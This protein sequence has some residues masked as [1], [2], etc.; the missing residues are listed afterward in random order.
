MCEQTVVIIVNRGRVPMRDAVEQRLLCL[1]TLN[2]RNANRQLVDATLLPLNS[3]IERHL[4]HLLR[5]TLDELSRLRMNTNGEG[6]DVASQFLCGG[7]HERETAAVA[8]GEATPHNSRIKQRKEAAV[9]G[10]HLHVGS[11][12]R[13]L[14][15]QW[16]GE[17]TVRTSLFIGSR[18]C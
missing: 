16:N 11:L 5:N 1:L 3:P 10:D 8:L 2:L 7:V 18:K 9:L 14:R 6:N 4:Q 13:D 15:S 12:L 17:T